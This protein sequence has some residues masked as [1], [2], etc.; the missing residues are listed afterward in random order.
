MFKHDDPIY[1]TEPPVRG[2]VYGYVMA[3]VPYGSVVTTREEVTEVTR[4]DEVTGAPYT[5]VIR[6]T[7]TFVGNREADWARGDPEKILEDLGLFSL[8]RDDNGDYTYVGIPIAEIEYRTG[9]SVFD[10]TFLEHECQGL[11]LRL[12]TIGITDAQPQIVFGLHYSY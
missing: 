10:P 5:K 11:K 2:F 9:A 7:K 1:V 12:A 3:A 8:S 4:Y 6:E